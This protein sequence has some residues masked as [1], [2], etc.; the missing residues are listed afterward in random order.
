MECNWGKR[1]FT[2]QLSKLEE[3]INQEKDLKRKLYLEKVLDVSNKLYYETFVNFPKSNVSAKQRLTSILESY[4]CY[5][6]YYSIV[7]AFFGKVSEHIDFIDEIS[8][9]L[10]SIS[11]NGDFDFINTGAVYSIDNI[12][13]L[14]KR[15]YKD[16]DTELYQYFLEV[17]EDRK[18]TLR[19]LPLDKTRDNKTDGNTSFIDGVRKNFITIYKTSPVS[20]YSCIVHEYGHAIANLINPESV[21]SDRE[22]MFAEVASIFP[23][24]IALYENVFNLDTI[25]VLY[26]MYTTLVTYTNSAEYLCLHA[27]VINTWA[28]HKYV[29][30]K[31]FFDDLEK[32]YD[33]DDECFEETLSST[34]E[35]Q[36]T[37]VISY[38]VSL[39]LLHLYKQDKEKALDLFK[40]FLK[41]PT[42][43]DVLTFVREN[44]SINEHV[45]EEASVVLNDFSKE[46]KRRY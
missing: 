43:E 3:L 15:F 18:D 34:I 36:G 8:D 40:R 30:G 23:E 46:L 37:Y 28:E 10:D 20:L 32:W 42:N 16:F 45:S 17:Y 2:E 39:E 44:I 35:D 27:P 7:N 33:F 1:E 25:E 9:K 4:L 11:P 12:L 38:I 19:F 13:S 5:G 21:Y 22:D 14:V 26:Q 29:M 41:I 24:L 6:R 31:S